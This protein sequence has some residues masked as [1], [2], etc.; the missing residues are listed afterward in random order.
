[1]CHFG[2]AH[3]FICGQASVSIK[4]YGI[5]KSIIHKG[6]VKLLHIRKIHIILKFMSITHTGYSYRIGNY[7]FLRIVSRERKWFNLV[8]IIFI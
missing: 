5:F 4:G 2:K 6:S 8:A 7:N 3:T 1:M